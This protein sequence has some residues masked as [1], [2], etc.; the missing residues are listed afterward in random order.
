VGETVLEADMYR[1]HLT[2]EDFPTKDYIEKHWEA[3]NNPN[4][5][6]WTG[7]RSTGGFGQTL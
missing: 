4:L 2:A 3:Y 1:I 7:D 6:I 5:T